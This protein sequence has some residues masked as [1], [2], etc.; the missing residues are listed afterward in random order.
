[1]RGIEKEKRIGEEGDQ[2]G[3]ERTRSHEFVGAVP[4]IHS[5]SRRG[6]RTSGA[7]PP[8]PRPQKRVGSLYGFSFLRPLFVQPSRR[9]VS[10]RFSSTR[11]QP[12]RRVTYVVVVH[13]HFLFP[14]RN[15]PR[16]SI[17]LRETDLIIYDDETKDTQTK[18][19]RTISF[20]RLRQHRSVSRLFTLLL[21]LLLFI[22][23]R[24]QRII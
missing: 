10:N 15:I 1:M 22:L 7:P 3:E 13:Y 6:K 12:V 18:G 14:R 23:Q 2:K 24:C 11:L 21:L 4:I 16:V 5:G 20:L 8:A 17:L 9:N 19:T